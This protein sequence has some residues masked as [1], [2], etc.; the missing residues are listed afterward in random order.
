MF[1]PSPIGIAGSTGRASCCSYTQ[2]EAYDLMRLGVGSVTGDREDHSTPH[3]SPGTP[4]PPLEYEYA[5]SD[6]VMSFMHDSRLLPA[7]QSRCAGG[8]RFL[9]VAETIHV[10]WA[11]IALHQPTTDTD[12]RYSVRDR[13]TTRTSSVSESHGTH[14]LFSPERRPKES[15]DDR[16]M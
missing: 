8:A 6:V 15:D 5:T 7:V 2:R 10:G 1:D 3:P 11:S 16:G 12:P 9:P 4:S 14:S 13:R